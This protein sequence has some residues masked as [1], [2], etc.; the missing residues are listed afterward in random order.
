M[1]IEKCIAFIEEAEKLKS[2]V[3]TAWTSSGR[4]ESTAEH[5]WRLAMLA[6]IMA[7]NDPGLDMA[8]VLMLC[9]IHDM[10]EIYD[11]DISAALNPDKED[12]Y[13][14]EYRA[15]KK[16]FSLLPGS[17]AKKLMDLWLE[18]NGN[19]TAEAKLVKAL[20]KAETII[21][22]NQG[23]NPPGFDYRFNLQYGK[24]YF[25]ENDDLKKLRTLIDAKTT[26]NCVTAGSKTK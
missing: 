5:S 18:Y 14:M 8:K 26:R 3:R 24:E 9:F 16:V 15:V 11:G 23:S 19:S 10:G 17:G 25:Q 20:D 12:K 13:D 4:R 7:A 1:E 22:H 21:Q 2:V 6:G